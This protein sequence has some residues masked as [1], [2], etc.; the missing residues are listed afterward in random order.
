M[1]MRMC[2]HALVLAGFVHACSFTSLSKPWSG[3]APTPSILMNIL[4]SD[5][6][7]QLPKV[8][9]IHFGRLCLSSTFH[10]PGMP[11]SCPLPGAAASLPCPARLE[12]SIG[13][14]HTE[15]QLLTLKC[16]SH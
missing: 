4:P 15:G 6:S 11:S 10:T 14:S 5:L 2:V 13:A 3:L 12:P 7:F 9:L 1:C 8:R 16:I